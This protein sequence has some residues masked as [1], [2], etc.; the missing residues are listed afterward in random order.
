LKMQIICDK[1]N[2]LPTRGFVQ[3]WLTD[4]ATRSAVLSLQRPNQVR[5]C[6]GIFKIA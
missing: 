3:V 5:V 6:F 2:E 1:N 4:F